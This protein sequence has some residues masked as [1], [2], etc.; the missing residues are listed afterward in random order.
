VPNYEKVNDVVAGSIAGVNG[1]AVANIQNVNGQDKPAGASGASLWVAGGNDRRVGYISNSDL[2]AGNNWSDYDA[3]A[4]GS[5]PFPSGSV[6][7]YYLGYGKDGSGNSLWVSLYETDNPEITIHDDGASGPWTGINTDEDGNNLSIRRFAVEWGNNVWI[8]VGKMSNTAKEVWRSTNGTDWEVIDI[9]GVTGIT[10]EGIYTI[11]SNGAGTW[12]FAQ[13]NRIYTS[14]SNGESGSWGLMH[15][16]LDGGSDPGKIRCMAYT[17]NTLL[18]G[19]LNNGKFYTAS[20]SDL[21]DWSGA[22]TLQHHA[23]LCFDD[24]RHIASAAGRV[25]VVGGQ[26]KSTFDINGKT[27]TMDENGADFSGDGTGHGNVYGVAT[28]GSTWVACSLT[29]DMFYSTNG[30]D[31]WVASTTNVGNEDMMHVAADVTLPL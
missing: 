28:D 10:T 24:Q 21:T 6:D 11:R 25:V 15:T 7:N 23:S 3:F 1:V 4:G 14:T 27:T 13:N 19:I 26:Y 2:L 29:G 8:A 5:S 18:V 9:S 17:N 31:T 20:T 12:W 16:L 22:T 30:G